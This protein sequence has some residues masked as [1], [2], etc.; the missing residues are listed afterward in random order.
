MAEYYFEV[1]GKYFPSAPKAF[2]MHVREEYGETAVWND[3]SETTS[4]QRAIDG[5]NRHFDFAKVLVRNLDV[6]GLQVF[7]YGLDDH[8]VL[9]PSRYTR[10]GKLKVRT[11][12]DDIPVP[13]PSGVA[14]LPDRPDPGPSPTSDSHQGGNPK[15]GQRSSQEAWDR[16]ARKFE[17]SEPGFF[18]PN[19]DKDARE[20]RDSSIVYRRGQPQFRSDLMEA[21]GECCAI[22]ACDVT[23]ALEAC[24]IRPYNGEKTN[25]V[26]N[27]LL[28]RADLHILFDKKLLAIDLEKKMVLLA[29][30]LKDTAYDFLDRANVRLPAREACWP[31][32]EALEM[33]RKE[34]QKTW[35]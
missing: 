29:P 35:G 16:K 11:V 13:L 8:V 14:P 27:G 31:N 3:V 10:R 2:W 32:R 34:A 4:G 19:D 7:M 23:E 1:E 24:H 17:Q 25:H 30:E 5:E 28:L 33:H 9:L 20:R 18:D 26:T 21:Y 6:A 22:T 15:E 12:R